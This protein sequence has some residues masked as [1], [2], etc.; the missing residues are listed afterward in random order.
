MY[1]YIALKL[2]LYVFW[3]LVAFMAVQCNTLFFYRLRREY[4]LIADKALTTPINTQH[5]MELKQ[6]VRTAEEKD[7]PILQ[8]KM[9]EAGN[10]GV[11][12]NI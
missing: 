1:M 2:F 10:R 5:L 8:D 12:I 9:L 7:L 3:R 11:H 6:F 4:E